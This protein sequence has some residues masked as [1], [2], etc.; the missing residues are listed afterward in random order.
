M[1]ENMPEAI[2]Q[3]GNSRLFCFVRKVPVY[4]L[5][6]SYD[7]RKSP[8]NH[9]PSRCIPKLYDPR[10]GLCV[11]TCSYGTGGLTLMGKSHPLLKG[12]C[13]RR[14]SWM[15]LTCQGY[16]EAPGR[17]SLHRLPVLLALFIAVT[18]FP[19]ADRHPPNTMERGRV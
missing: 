10:V 4:M 1:H 11:F 7:G 16:H 6:E 19:Q 18:R 3:S 15:L 14:G 2:C 9:S 5:E 12:R 8:W 13:T 17:L